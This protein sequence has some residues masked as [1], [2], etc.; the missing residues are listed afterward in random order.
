MSDSTFQADG[1]I[2]QI[3]EAYSLDAIDFVRE[4]FKVKL[5][6]TDASI[7]HIENVLDRFHREIHQAKPSPEQVYQFAKMFGSY[8]GEVYRR[9][10]GARWG[11]VEIGGQKMPGLQSNSGGL[12]WPWGKVNNRLTNGPEDNVLHYYQFLAKEKNKS[13]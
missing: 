5:D 10:H 1:K 3:A 13:A 12:F 8:V 9:N 11:I 4:N 7:S 6:W 2:Q